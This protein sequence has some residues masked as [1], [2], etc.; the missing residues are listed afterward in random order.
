MGTTQIAQVAP[1]A[2]LNLTDGRV[3]LQN[4]KNLSLLPERI[5]AGGAT[6]LSATG[7]A[8]SYAGVNWE[9]F[10]IR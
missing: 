6:A 8:T 2:G 7:A 1:E 4:L 9:P 3:T 5:V 10:L